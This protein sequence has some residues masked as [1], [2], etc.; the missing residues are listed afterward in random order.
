MERYEL[1]TRVDESPY[2]SREFNDLEIAIEEAIIHVRRFFVAK[3]NSCDISAEAEIRD[4]D[5]D[6]ADTVFLLFA[7]DVPYVGLPFWDTE[8]PD[9]G[10]SKRGQAIYINYPDS[11]TH[12]Y[13]IMSSESPQHIVREALMDALDG[14]EVRASEPLILRARLFSFGK[15]ESC[16]ELEIS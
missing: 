13:E 4:L 5:S 7:Y 6:G 14:I 3:E 9:E 12:A 2:G 10:L 1:L 8:E 11:R 16:A 15:F